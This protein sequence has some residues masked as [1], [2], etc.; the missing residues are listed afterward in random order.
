MSPDKIPPNSSPSMENICYN[1]GAVPTK[2]AG[3]ARI[4]AASL[5]PTPIR[6]MVDFIQIGKEDEFLVVHGGNLYRKTL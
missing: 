2:R 5:G 6:D 4:T 3:F 1:D